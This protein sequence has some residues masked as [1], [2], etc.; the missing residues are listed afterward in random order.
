MQT[1][2]VRRLRTKESEKPT[3]RKRVVGEIGF[4]KRRINGAEI[5]GKDHHHH[6][7]G[8]RTMGNAQIE[9]KAET[10]GKEPMRNEN[11]DTVSGEKATPAPVRSELVLPYA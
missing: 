6:R 10:V 2:K 4:L 1:A 7:D 8:A 11:V 3:K 9:G 5:D